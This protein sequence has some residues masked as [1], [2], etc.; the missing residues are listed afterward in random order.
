[1][2]Y[3]I[4]SKKNINKDFNKEIIKFVEKIKENFKYKIIWSNGFIKESL[5]SCINNEKDVVFWVPDLAYTNMNLLSE[6]KYSIVILEKPTILIQKKSR[7]NLINENDAINKNFLI[8][9]LKPDE[10]DDTN[11]EWRLIVSDDVWLC[12]NEKLNT[13]LN[14]T[15]QFE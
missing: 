1:M 10:N 12:D 4:L 2:I 13:I 15:K 3:F 8:Y 5:L 11:K 7:S 9:Y 6:F 14:N